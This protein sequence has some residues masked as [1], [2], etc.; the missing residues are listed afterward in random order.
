MAYGDIHVGEV[1][2]LAALENSLKESDFPFDPGELLKDDQ[3]PVQLYD[4]RLPWN[5]SKKHSG[6]KN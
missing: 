6:V 2:E 1:Q 5:L 3:S 4:L